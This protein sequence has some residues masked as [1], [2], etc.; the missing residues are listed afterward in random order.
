MGGDDKSPVGRDGTTATNADR[1]L[2]EP[3]CLHASRCSNALQCAGRRTPS[4]RTWRSDCALA[5]SKPARPAG[6]SGWQSTTSCCGS[7]RS[8][9]IRCVVRDSNSGHQLLLP[10]A[11]VCVPDHAGGLRWPELSPAD[12]KLRV[13]GQLKRNRVSVGNNLRI[14]GISDRDTVHL[15]CSPLL[16]TRHPWLVQRPSDRWRAGECSSVTCPHAC[17]ARRCPFHWN[18]SSPEKLSQANPLIRSTQS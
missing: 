3:D 8:L 12:P 1:L 10:P 4:S 7:R 14:K 6:P 16:L 5:R 9:A 15:L 2:S 18:C 17:P 13:G 11:H